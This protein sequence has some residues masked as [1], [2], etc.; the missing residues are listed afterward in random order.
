MRKVMTNHNQL[1]TQQAIHNSYQPTHQLQAVTETLGIN[2]EA[3]LQF[4]PKIRT[5][6][7]QFP[8]AVFQ[9]STATFPQG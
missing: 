8:Q 9:C 7:K 1:L 5:W 3:K 6:W 2:K 4:F